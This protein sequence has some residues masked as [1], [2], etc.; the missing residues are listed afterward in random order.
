MEKQTYTTTLELDIDPKKLYPL[1]ST[2]AG[3]ASWFCDEAEET[4]E[5]SFVMTWNNKPHRSRILSRKKN[6]SIKWAFLADENETQDKDAPFV[7]FLIS[8]GNLEDL[9]YLKITDY[10]KNTDNEALASLWKELSKYLM[11]AIEEDQEI[12]DI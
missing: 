1:L 5:G 7:E 8:K 10:A 6:K 12:Q 2:P 3:M 9:V 11:Q 4:S